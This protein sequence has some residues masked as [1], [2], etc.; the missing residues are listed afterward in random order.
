MKI[1][2][3]PSGDRPD[4]RP[5]YKQIITADAVPAPQ[6]LVDDTVPD[7]GTQPI[8]ATNYTSQEFYQKEVEKVWLKCWQMACREEEIPQVGDY[9]IYEIVG[10]SLLIVRTAPNEIKAL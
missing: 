1:E 7:L 5:T 10:R 3:L 2:F 8:P 9:L 4:Q 6:W